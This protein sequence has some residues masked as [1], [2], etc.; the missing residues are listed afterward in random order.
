[1]SIYHLKFY[2]FLFFVLILF[3]FNTFRLTPVW[4]IENY[5]RFFFSM[6]SIPILLF[7]F[8]RITISK[9]I[10]IF[11]LVG[12]IS[13]YAG[14]AFL[15]QSIISG[16]IAA[17]NIWSCANVILLIYL[18]IRCGMMAKK[19]EQF[20]IYAIWIQALAIII[21]YNF[22]IQIIY[23]SFFT[24]STLTNDAGQLSSAFIQFG[25]IYYFIKY[26]SQAKSKFLFYSIFFLVFP[27]FIEFQRMRFLFITATL[28]FIIYKNIHVKRFFFLL[29]FI[30]AGVLIFY[31]IF[32][33]NPFI[34]DLTAKLGEAFKLF[35]DHSTISD[36]STMARINEFN[37]MYSYIVQHPIIGNG[38]PRSSVIEQ[39]FGEGIYLHYSDMG[40]IG[41]LFVSGIIG[42]LIFCWQNYI[43][44]YLWKTSQ[45]KSTFFQ[46]LV[47]YLIFITLSSYGTGNIYHSPYLYFCV[48]V[49]LFLLDYEYT[50][51]QIYYRSYIGKL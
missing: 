33:N 21:L 48:I 9:G 22:N 19:I 40:I 24:G 44:Y 47:Y 10:V 46:S 18:F 45:Q 27:I 36:P 50:I 8:R 39:L 20:F 13:V 11:Y 49:L 31:W 32:A 28:L 35:G 12:T 34:L 17:I 2:R 30:P 25:V 23:R 38:F 41:I 5:G 14:F 6:I 43:V 42:F 29:L 7:E 4:D 37:F 1:M 3:N 51:K 26:V 16:F 15:D